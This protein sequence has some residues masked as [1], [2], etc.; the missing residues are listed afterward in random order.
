MNEKLGIEYIKVFIDN[1]DGKN[2]CI[3]MRN[4]KRCNKQCT[5]DVVERDRYRNWEDTFHV[6]KY[7]KS[8]S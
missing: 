5:P 2:L 6:D 8:K 1:K 3:C 4:N 7:G